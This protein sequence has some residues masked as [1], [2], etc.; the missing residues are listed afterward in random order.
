MVINLPKLGPVKFR[1]DLSP[2]EFQGQLQ[3][4]SAKY[5][6]ELPKTDYGYLG[7]F[8]KGVSRGM[9]R[10]GETLGDVLPAMVGSAL[11]ADEYA[12]AQLG[13]AAET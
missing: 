12:K 13:E 11:G 4:L 7:S 6:F 8:T 2:E 10:M 3:T 9:T 5:G 1:D